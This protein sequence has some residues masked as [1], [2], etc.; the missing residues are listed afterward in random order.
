MRSQKTGGTGHNRNRL[1]IF[2][3]HCAVYLKAWA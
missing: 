1:R 3:G 2:C